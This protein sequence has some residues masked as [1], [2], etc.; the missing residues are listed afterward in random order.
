MA[1]L[2]SVQKN[3]LRER[4]IKK[5][6]SKREALKTKIKDKKIP[7]EERILYQNNSHLDHIICNT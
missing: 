6:K 4:L 2:S 1:I 3:L 7:L 5:Y